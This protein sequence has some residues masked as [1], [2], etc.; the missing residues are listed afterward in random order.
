MFTSPEFI[1]FMIASSLLTI[2]PGPDIIF[3]LTQ[4]INHGAKSGFVTALGLASGNLVHTLAAALGISL[5]FQTSPFALQLLKLLGVIYLLYLAFETIR[6]KQIHSHKP[7]LHVRGFS[8]YLRGVLMNALNPKVALF[9]IAFLPQ[10]IIPDL[11][12]VWQQTVIYGITFTLIVTLIFGS[13][14]LLA[15]YMPTYLSIQKRNNHWTRWLTAG[16]FISLAIHL[17]LTKF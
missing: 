4:S 2:A 6:N 17:S 5:I 15:G 9:Y 10:F 1:Y 3:L 16:V 8:L 7:V 13:I 14:G 12:P 11:R